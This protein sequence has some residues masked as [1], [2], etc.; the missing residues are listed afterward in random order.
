MND[1]YHHVHSEGI[2]SVDFCFQ[3]DMPLFVHQHYTSVFAA[4][5]ARDPAT[6]ATGAIN[7]P[8]VGGDDDQPPIPYDVMY[9]VVTYNASAPPASVFNAPAYCHGCHH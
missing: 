8:P 6:V 7:E 5:A 9:E 3:G 4:V 2:L 1:D